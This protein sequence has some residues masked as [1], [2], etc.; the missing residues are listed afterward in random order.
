MADMADTD[1]FRANP[2]TN[3]R[4]RPPGPSEVDELA[5]TLLPA[6]RFQPGDVERASVIRGLGEV[7]WSV[8]AV[9]ADRRRTF[10]FLSAASSIG[11]AFCVATL[12]AEGGRIAVTK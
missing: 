11:A 3:F 12:L 5:S 7:E 4:L 10:R 8:L 2:T 1:W 9:R 6:G